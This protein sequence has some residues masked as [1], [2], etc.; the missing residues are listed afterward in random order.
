MMYSICN[1]DVMPET[2]LKSMVLTNG[3]I[4]SDSALQFAMENNAKRQNLVYNMPIGASKERPQEMLIRNIADG[5]ET[6]VSCVSPA[7]NSKASVL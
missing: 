6:V 1:Y 7:S 4:F 5:Y 3:I 2:Y